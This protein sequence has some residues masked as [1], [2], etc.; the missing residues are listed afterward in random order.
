MIIHSY[1]QI[2]YYN[3][4]T[5]EK[6][7]KVQT[8]SARQCEDRALIA[9]I[10]PLGDNSIR[11]YHL[12]S[13]SAISAE[14]LSMS[15]PSLPVLGGVDEPPPLTANTYSKVSNPLGNCLISI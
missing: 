5:L 7:P 2:Q 13:L 12:S 6:S 10:Y 11:Y 15:S 8:I 4:I 3:F 1:I 14:V 9:S